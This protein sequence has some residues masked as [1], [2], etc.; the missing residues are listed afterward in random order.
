[1]SRIGIWDKRKPLQNVNRRSFQRKVERVVKKS[2]L[3]IYSVT[4]SYMFPSYETVIMLH[5]TVKFAC[6][7]PERK[8]R[9]GQ[10]RPLILN[11]GTR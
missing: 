11:L 10:A 1:M 7:A 3:S 9:G 4:T 6:P 2:C 8:V 5:I